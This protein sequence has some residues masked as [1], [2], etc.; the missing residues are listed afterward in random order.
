MNDRLAGFCMG[1]GFG[2]VVG[3]GVM[4][5]PTDVVVRLGVITLM[6]CFVLGCMGVADWWH[7]ERKS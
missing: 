7:D 3:A 1:L 5:A 2:G 6:L 4:I